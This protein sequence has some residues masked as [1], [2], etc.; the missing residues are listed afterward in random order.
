MKPLTAF[1]LLSINVIIPGMGSIIGKQREGWYQITLL[2]SGITI[3]IYG[4][5]KQNA[6]GL[7][8]MFSGA[9]LILTAMIWALYSSFMMARQAAISESQSRHQNKSPD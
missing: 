8:L 2:I 3:G 9:V 1:I 4:G 7:L 6:I 5:E